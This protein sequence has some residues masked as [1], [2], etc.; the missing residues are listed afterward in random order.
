MAIRRLLAGAALGVVASFGLP[1][2]AAVADPAYPPSVGG[3]TVSSTSVSV[4]G[5][6]SIAGTGFEP[7]STA[8]VTVRVRNVGITDNFAVVADAS[9]N[10]GASVKL[11][12]SG[13]TTIV[14][15]GVDADGAPHVL[16]T[17]VE[18]ASTGA[19]A[20]P[21]GLGPSPKRGLPDTGANIRTPLVLGAALVLGGVGALLSTRRRR[22]RAIAE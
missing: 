21:L 13:Q 8:T 14:V 1:A 10:I 7:G 22:R 16:T 5:S 17:V 15:T 12:S 2:V 18:A 20:P 6:V 9:G 3:L 4:G 19:A 11:T